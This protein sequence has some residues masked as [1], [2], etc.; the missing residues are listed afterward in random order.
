MAASRSKARRDPNDRPAFT[1]VA[2]QTFRG[3]Q[4]AT[5]SHAVGQGATAVDSHLKCSVYVLLYS[6]GTWGATNCPKSGGDL[7]SGH[8]AKSL[9][10]V[11]ARQYA[12]GQV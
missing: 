3:S 4:G 5:Q 6:E 9:C 7:M 12:S 11:E 10:S 2:A 1:G 8:G